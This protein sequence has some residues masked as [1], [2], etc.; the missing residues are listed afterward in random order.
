MVWNASSSSYMW[1]EQSSLLRKNTSLTSIPLENRSSPSFAFNS[2]DRAWWPGKV[3]TEILRQNSREKI[4]SRL[5]SWSFYFI[6]ATRT[7]WCWSFTFSCSKMPRN[8]LQ[9][10]AG[11]AAKKLLS[12]SF[13]DK[14]PLLP[15][16]WIENN[17][18]LPCYCVPNGHLTWPK[19]LG[20]FAQAEDDLW[21]ALFDLPFHSGC[22]LFC[23]F[24]LHLNCK[25]WDIVHISWA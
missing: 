25:F 5:M 15:V 17:V 1:S 19:W 14:T 23:G 10:Q 7:N 4:V 18:C 24:L 12:A 22:Q 11:V 13:S 16:I 21:N 6:T 20:T 8:L 2:A 9:F 3:K